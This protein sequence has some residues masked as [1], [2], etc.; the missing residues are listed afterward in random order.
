MVGKWTNE[1][2]SGV[3]EVVNHFWVLTPLIDHRGE[4][5]RRNQNPSDSSNSTPKAHQIDPNK[6]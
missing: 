3:D 5:D 4:L 1:P 2:R 6:Y